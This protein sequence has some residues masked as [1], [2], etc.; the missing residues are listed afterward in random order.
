MR[1]RLEIETL[2]EIRVLKSSHILR[3]STR[4][5][6]CPELGVRSGKT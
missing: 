5:P 3:A 6:A 4:S 2:G 1:V